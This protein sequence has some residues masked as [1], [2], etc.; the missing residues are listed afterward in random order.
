MKKIFQTLFS[1]SLSFFFFLPV[2][3]QQ[4]VQ[5]PDCWKDGN[6]QLNDAVNTLISVA[7][8]I[9]GISGSFALLM[10]IYGGFTWVTSAG[11][12]ERITKGKTIVRNAVIGL[13]VVFL[14]YG[15]INFALSALGIGGGFNLLKGTAQKT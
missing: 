13:V 10:F 1:L 11:S 2:H 4:V 5:A 9:L 14:S 8:F 3:A 12:E 15:I 7:S 6:C